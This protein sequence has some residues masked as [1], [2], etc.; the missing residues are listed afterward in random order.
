MVAHPR[1]DGLQPCH[2]PLLAWQG[3]ALEGLGAVMD[4]TEAYQ[5]P[6]SQQLLYPAQ[7]EVKK[8][9]KR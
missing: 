1:T 4:A 9:L 5:N 3:R 2:C 7:V 8:A 6:L